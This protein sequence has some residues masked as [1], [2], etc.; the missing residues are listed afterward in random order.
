MD[1]V[2][3][4]VH[5]YKHGLAEA[6]IR[7]AWEHFLC[8]QYRGAPNEGQILAVGCDRSGRAM[9]LVAVER[10][11]GVL[12]YHAMAPPTDKALVELG[13]KRR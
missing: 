10:A 7:Y 11:C 2:V 5:A 3:V 1:E 6:D 9:Q 4:A 8:R 12:I 13:L